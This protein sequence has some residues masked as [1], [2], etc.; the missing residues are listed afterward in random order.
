M[1]NGGAVPAC[2]GDC[3]VVVLGL[4][5]KKTQA[6]EASD[7]VDGDSLIGSALSDGD[8]GGVVRLRLH[9]AASARTSSARVRSRA[10]ANVTDS[11]PSGSI[12]SRN[13]RIRTSS[14]PQQPSSCVCCIAVHSANPASRSAS[15]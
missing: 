5:R 9:G 11:W 1:F 6:V 7:G 14:K 3:E 8:G 10:L 2:G 13:P 12:R 15:S 4:Q